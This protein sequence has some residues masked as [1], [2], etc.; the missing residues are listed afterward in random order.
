[1]YNFVFYYNIE[2]SGF[3]AVSVYLLLDFGA[4]DKH[5]EGAKNLSQT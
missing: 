4:S 1:M 2:K 5:I 3:I